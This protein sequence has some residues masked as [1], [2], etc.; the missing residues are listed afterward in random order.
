[1]PM[2]S[3]HQETTGGR[4]FLAEKRIRWNFKTALPQYY[5]RF[6]FMSFLLPLALINDEVVDIALV[7]DTK[8]IRIITLGVQ[9]CR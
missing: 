4:K 3:P 7:V 9:F 2:Y 8:R 1:M 6:D 5:P